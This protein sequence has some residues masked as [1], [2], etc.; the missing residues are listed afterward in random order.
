MHNNRLGPKP[1][2]DLIPTLSFLVRFLYLP[3]GSK[4][5]DFFFFPW[6]ISL[7]DALL[8]IHFSGRSLG[9][10]PYPVLRNDAS[11]HILTTT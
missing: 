6:K 8:G 3:R 4:E 5:A 7:S 9:V 10:F 11:R 1:P 2:L